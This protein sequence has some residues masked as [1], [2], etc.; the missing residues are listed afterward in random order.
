MTQNGRRRELPWHNADRSDAGGAGSG[1][2]EALP[3]QHVEGLR[4]RERERHI[5]LR[6]R[7][8]EDKDI[9]ELERPARWRLRIAHVERLTL[10]Q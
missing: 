8:G 1:D 4:L 9:A 2:L 10:R 7:C 6:H 3:D 5:R